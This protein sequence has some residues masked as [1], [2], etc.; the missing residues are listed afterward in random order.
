MDFLVII[1]WMFLVLGFDS[2][3]TAQASWA[4]SEL[5]CKIRDRDISSKTLH[6]CE[7][8][9]LNLRHVACIAAKMIPT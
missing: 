1:D 8:S 5:R 6:R 3:G 7:R 4:G 2:W 9:H